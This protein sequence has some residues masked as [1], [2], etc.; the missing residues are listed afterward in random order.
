MHPR[1]ATAEQL[2]AR[3]EIYD[4][5]MHYMRGVDRRNM[6]LVRAA[7]HPDAV[8]TNPY[9][10]PGEWGSVEE[11][12]TLINRNAVH[13]P[14]SMHLLANVVYE[15]AGDDVA[16]VESYLMAYQTHRDAEG[17]EGFR[18]TGSRYLDRF[19]RRDGSWKIAKRVLPLNFIRP[20]AQAGDQ[21]LFTNPVPSTR[22]ADDPLWAL[23]A[24]AGLE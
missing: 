1:P 21:I 13:I 22:D 23:R 18:Q 4:V 17:E 19:E 8:Q 14:M 10:G 12:I 3:A 15:F 16:I 20:L 7:Y 5:L 6:E 11:L 24:E 9:L 2:I